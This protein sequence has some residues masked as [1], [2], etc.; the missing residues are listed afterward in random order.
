LSIGSKNI[1]LIAKRILGDPH[2]RGNRLNNSQ[3]HT[4]MTG[5]GIFADQIASLF[6]VACRRAGIGERP[7]FR[8]AA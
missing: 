3:W 5:E 4:R 6:E 2:L 1:F 8:P 7:S